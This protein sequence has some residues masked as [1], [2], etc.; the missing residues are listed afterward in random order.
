MI[1]RRAIHSS[2]FFQSLNDDIFQIIFVK[3]TPLGWA[4]AL[5]ANV[6]LGWKYLQQ[7]NTS[8]NFS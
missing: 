7:A 6:G 5:I 4:P 2:L 1:V 3:L 8:T